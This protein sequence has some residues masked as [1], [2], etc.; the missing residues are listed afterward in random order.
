M[1]LGEGGLGVDNAATISSR[2]TITPPFNEQMT[3]TGDIDGHT[4]FSTTRQLILPF[5]I[6]AKIGYAPSGYSSK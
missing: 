4:I 2:K 6:T 3:D 1:F 5:G